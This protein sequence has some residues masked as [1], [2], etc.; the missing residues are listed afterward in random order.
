MRLCKEPTDAD[1][2]AALLYQIMII[3]HKEGPLLLWA[4]L[5]VE[6]NPE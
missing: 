6:W 3:L 4:L 1:L 5:G 2:R